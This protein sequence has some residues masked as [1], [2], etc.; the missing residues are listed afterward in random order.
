MRI[1]VAVSTAR[2]SW[3]DVPCRSPHDAMALELGLQWS[4]AHSAELS[5]LH[6]GD[7]ADPALRLYCGMGVAHAHVL[8]DVPPNGAAR[9][10]AHYISRD[11]PDIV[12]MGGRGGHLQGAGM[13]P[14]QVAKMLAM[15]L[16][17]RVTEAE[18][19]AG[20]WRV[21]QQ[22]PRGAR[23][24]SLVN[25]PWIGTVGDGGPTPRQVA[26]ARARDA[27]IYPI[28][29]PPQVAEEM[30][31]MRV[32]RPARRRGA[33]TV[34][35]HAAAAER[36]QALFGQSSSRGQLISEGTPQEMAALLLRKLREL[37]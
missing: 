4:A 29:S 18:R 24:R 16:L 2:H 10:L 32:A 9:A 20:G 22:L 25:S 12:L 13:I 37:L 26:F 27:I 21:H 23:R 7:S 28:A 8:T 5:L 15:P 14:Y 11:E 33:V 30:P 36:R 19:I 35:A 17:A 3:T 6:C 31:P 1:L 34:V